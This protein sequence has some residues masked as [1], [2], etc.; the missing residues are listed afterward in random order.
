M[1]SSLSLIAQYLATEKRVEIAEKL[2]ADISSNPEAIDA[3]CQILDVLDL[4]ESSTVFANILDYS[5][6]I[7]YSATSE[8]EDEESVDYAN[9]LKFAAKLPKLRQQLLS[10]ILSSLKTYIHENHN[11]IPEFDSIVEVQNSSASDYTEP[12]EISNDLVLS[13]FSFLHSFF[14]AI[15]DIGDLDQSIDSVLLKLLSINDEK[16]SS[17]ISK[18]LRWRISYIAEKIDNSDMLWKIIFALESSGKKYH[19]SHAFILWLR[20]LD[21]GLAHYEV[22]QNIVKTERYWKVLQSGLISDSHEFRKFCLS[23][24]QLSVKSINCSF[25]NSIMS[26]D[27]TKSSLYLSEWARYCTL[28]EIMAIDTSLHQAEAGRR[29]ITGL[30]SPQSFI[31]PSWGFCLLST[32]FKASMDS[33]RKFSL[34]LLLSIPDEHLH[35]IKY[36]LKFLEEVYLPYAMLAPHYA[37]RPEDGVNKCIFGEIMTKFIANL[38]VNLTSEKEYQDVALSI[39]NVLENLKETFDPSRIYIA[40]GLL[41]GLSN[42]MVLRFD[43]H[44]SVL[45][46]IFEVNAEGDLFEKVIQTINF[47]ILLHFKITQNTLLSFFELLNLFIRFNGNQIVNENFTLIQE[48]LQTNEIDSQSLFS[49][50]KDEN[51]TGDLKALIIKVLNSSQD[52]LLCYLSNCSGETIAQVI[53][54]SSELSILSSPQ[55][56]ELF[57]KIITQKPSS[58]I[59]SSLAT[60]DFENLQALIPSKSYISDLWKSII[61]ESQS[62]E[63]PVLELMLQK[64]KFFNNIYAHSTSVVMDF[65]GLVEL[66]TK[67]LSKSSK[68]VKSVKEFYKLKEE[69]YGEYYKT[70]EI[71]STKSK[72]YSIEDILKVLNS[73]S[74]N[75]RANFSMVQLLNNFLSTNND[76]QIA[77]LKKVVKF[78]TDLWKSLDSSRLQLNQKDLHV[79]MIDTILHPSLLSLSV[80]DDE[81]SQ[82]LFEFAISVLE[83][84]QGRRSLLPALA[85]NLS[86]Y[87]VEQHEKFEALPWVVE[88]LVRAFIVY[89][90]RNNVFKLE[91]IIGDIYD[92]RISL[93]SGCDLYSSVYG[94]EEVSAKIYLMAIFNSVKTSTFANQIVNFIF[95]NEREFYFLQV[96]KSTDGFEEWRRIQ[97]FT[98]IVSVLDIAGFEDKL[99]TLMELVGTDPSPLVRVFI[100]WILSFN[101]LKSKKY[102]QQILEDLSNEN[103]NLKPTVITSYERIIFLMISQLSPEQEV[104]VLQNF[105]AVIIP[106]AT[107]NKAVTRHFSLSLVVSI[108]EEIESKKLK[109]DSHLKEI[110]FNMYKSASSSESYGQFRSGDAL[111]WDIKQDL[112]LVSISGGVLMRVSDRDIFDYISRQSYLKYLTPQQSQFLNHAIG[113]E[114]KDLWIRDKLIQKR[115]VAKTGTTSQSPLQTKSG[116]WN[117][118]MDVDE[119]TRGKEVVRSDLIVVSSL[120][121]KPPNLGGIC[122]LCDVLGAGLLTL[123]DIKVKSHPQFKNVAVTADYWM[124]MI[125]VKPEDIKMYLREK[126]REGYTLIGLEQTDKSV[127]LNNELQFPK[128]SLILLGREKEG[129]PGDLL[130]ELDF[131]V[132]IKQV[133]VIRS[134][135]IQT[136]TAIIVHAYSTQHC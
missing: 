39:L 25:E 45:L 37:V 127:E 46:K 85:K 15:P 40:H 103:A 106:G 110:V 95:E 55:L 117:T 4:E 26:W 58:V 43:I 66:E 109:I 57:N 62:D 104:Q 133:G 38:L 12:I 136:A 59:Y 121:D 126:K 11:F 20:Y 77:S 90:I 16:I 49:L 18:L 73:D 33:V 28:F 74:S 5:T 118:V 79:L 71:T 41:L 44:R 21:S 32:G 81:T 86:T 75:H 23:I 97:L 83:N 13:L 51:V 129:V 34:D 101:L 67:I 54:S 19:K 7:I 107:S 131:C 114:H 108:Y 30:I 102:V 125:E 61:S 92:R 22:Y 63:L 84:A 65:V 122:R 130:A 134:M 68:L 27:S 42:K 50:L 72:G 14:V 105:L 9:V 87:Q 88:I 96:N 89:Q 24:L 52:Q 3:L 47:R 10:K 60:V 82:N 80:D 78:L 2:S 120:V 29:D 94:P 31:H 8:E 115:S 1:S 132:E 70:L 100:E 123:N 36:G 64:H 56:V 128:K 99:D 124:P 113:L 111:L 35:L 6:K 116:A 17:I 91:N 76:T 48:Y 119:T 98:I 53:Q 135:N 69:I 93:T 112:S